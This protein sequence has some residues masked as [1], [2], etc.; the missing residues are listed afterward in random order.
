MDALHRQ[1][2]PA[3]VNPQVAVAADEGRT[4]RRRAGAPSMNTGMRTG[5]LISTCGLAEIQPARRITNVWYAAA[6]ARGESRG[7]PYR[8]QCAPWQD[9]DQ[10]RRVMSGAGA[11]LRGRTIQGHH[12]QNGAVNS[13]NRLTV[14]VTFAGCG[15]AFG[16]GGRLQACIHLRPDGAPPVLL[17]CGATS[18]TALKRCGLDPGEVGVVF[19]SHL[20]GDHFG[21]L[22]F[23]VLDGQFSGRADPLTVVGPPGTAARLRSAMECLFPGSTA[24]RRRV[25]VRVTE[26][27]PGSPVPAGGGEAAAGAARP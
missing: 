15:D 20:H 12:A 1:R 17:D 22:P 26:L 7:H 9:V 25:A 19:V 14:T 21:G 8:R 11:A 23:L 24:A 10:V 3:A 13:A 18:L 6:G 16:S 4:R 5:W 27:A 2:P